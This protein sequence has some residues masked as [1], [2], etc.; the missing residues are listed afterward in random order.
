MQRV[1]LCCVSLVLE[2]E[3]GEPEPGAGR[4]RGTAL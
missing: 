2:Y 3:E 1:P 4:N